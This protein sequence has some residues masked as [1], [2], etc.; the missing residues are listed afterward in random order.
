MP[1]SYDTSM[2]PTDAFTVLIDK[3]QSKAFYEFNA[4][5]DYDNF[6]K[7]PQTSLGRLLHRFLNFHLF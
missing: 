2:M 5:Q 3:K 7:I 1:R 4:F 6:N